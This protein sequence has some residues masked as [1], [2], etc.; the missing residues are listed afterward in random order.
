MGIAYKKT[1]MRMEHSSDEEER[2]SGTVSLRASVHL[3][4]AHLFSISYVIKHVL[5]HNPRS[6]RIEY[7]WISASIMFPNYPFNPYIYRC[8]GYAMKSEEGCAVGHFDTHPG[9]FQKFFH[10]CL[11]RKTIPLGKMYLFSA[12]PFHCLVNVGSPVPQRAFPE[13]LL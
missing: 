11:I 5:L 3:R 10:K 13:V 1:I 8:T 2:I 7:K 12:Y 4:P 9:K 6:F